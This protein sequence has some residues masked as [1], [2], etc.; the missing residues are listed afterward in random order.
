MLALL[1]EPN[2]NEAEAAP[3]PTPASA[4]VM[5]RNSTDEDVSLLI[6]CPVVL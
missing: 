6:I 4:K 5:I 1:K 2:A 3:A